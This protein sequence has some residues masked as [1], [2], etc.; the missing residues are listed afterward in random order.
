MSAEKDIEIEEAVG[1]DPSLGLTPLE[2]MNRKAEI[3]EF[4]LTML[5]RLKVDCGFRSI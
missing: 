1:E 5:K 3:A 4:M 2:N